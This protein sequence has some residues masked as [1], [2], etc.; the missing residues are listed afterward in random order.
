MKR[1]IQTNASFLKNFLCINII[2]A[3]AEG[4]TRNSSKYAQ[5]SILW[6]IWLAGMYVILTLGCEAWVEECT[7][8]GNITYLLHHW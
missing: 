7:L 6:D 5:N 8:Y 3:Q 2:T 4:Y 1:H